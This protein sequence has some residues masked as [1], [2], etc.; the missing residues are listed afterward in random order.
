MEASL[1]PLATDFANRVSSG[2]TKVIAGGKSFAEILAGGSS[3]VPTTTQAAAVPKVKLSAE[4]Q[5]LLDKL[6]DLLKHTLANQGIPWGTEIGLS[7]DVLGEIKVAGNHADARAIEQAIA[8]DGEL[9]TL[10]DQLLGH[11][12]G[13]ASAALQLGQVWNPAAP[14]SQRQIILGD[15]QAFVATL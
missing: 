10:A 6:R 2:I 7:R 1:L 5:K 3:N 11:D 8:S 13:S 4:N 14:T 12:A 9:S 15:E